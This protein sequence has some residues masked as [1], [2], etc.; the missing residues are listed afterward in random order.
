MTRERGR[1]RLADD[2]PG[3]PVHPDIVVA[4]VE[5]ADFEDT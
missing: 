2:P 3:L 4:D 5:D 1:C